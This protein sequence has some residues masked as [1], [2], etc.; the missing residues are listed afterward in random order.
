M[1]RHVWPQMHNATRHG[2][3]AF[4]TAQSTT[5]PRTSE[6]ASQLTSVSL[7]A[8]QLSKAATSAS[9]ACDS[10]ARGPVAQH[11]VN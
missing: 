10:S 4:S 2:A 1:G 8:W 11:L 3:N 9:T 7:S 6:A 5:N